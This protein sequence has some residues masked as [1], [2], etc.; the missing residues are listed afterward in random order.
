MQRNAAEQ[1]VLKLK[2]PW[3]DGKR[4]T[5]HQVVPVLAVEGQLF[6]AGLRDGQDRL[7]RVQP[8]T[9]RERSRSRIP[10]LLSLLRRPV[11]SARM[12]QSSDSLAAE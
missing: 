5:S 4:S 12:E 10:G 7:G 8:I 2:T 11:E 6:G 9:D 1:A 3:L